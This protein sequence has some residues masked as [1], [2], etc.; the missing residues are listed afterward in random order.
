M[1]VS[2]APEYLLYGRGFVAYEV[3]VVGQVVTIFAVQLVELLYQR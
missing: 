1:I 2:D 3:G